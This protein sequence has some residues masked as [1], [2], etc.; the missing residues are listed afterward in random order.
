MSTEDHEVDDKP[1]FVRCNVC[2]G[3]GRIYNSPCEY[4][5]TSVTCWYCLGRC[6]HDRYGL[7]VRGEN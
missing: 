3:R 6:G 2:E 1:R 5:L 7:I 4:L